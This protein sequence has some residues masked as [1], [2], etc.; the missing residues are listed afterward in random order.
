MNTSTSAFPTGSNQPCPAKRTAGPCGT[1][2]YGAAH[3]SNDTP[4]AHHSPARGR[5]S[6]SASQ[7]TKRTIQMK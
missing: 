1:H 3:R 4:S 2:Q 5:S 7:A 6:A